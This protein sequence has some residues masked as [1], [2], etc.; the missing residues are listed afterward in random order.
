MHKNI[1][2]L[3]ARRISAS[4]V[5]GNKRST[6]CC[7]QRILF[8]CLDRFFWSANVSFSI[9]FSR[10]IGQNKRLAAT[11]HERTA[12]QRG[13][14]QPVTPKRTGQNGSPTRGRNV[15]LCV[16]YISQAV[17][18]VIRFLPIPS[19]NYL[20]ERV[21]F[22]FCY[23]PQKRPSTHTPIPHPTLFRH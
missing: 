8:I 2:L 20:R 5:P 11:I 4:E 10:I 6:R 14:S 13:P 18:T 21:L 23:F 22:L 3:F 19:L 9:F 1:S 12:L 7:E 15:P 16:P 17:S